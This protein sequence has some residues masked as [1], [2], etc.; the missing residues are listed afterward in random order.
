MGL[1]KNIEKN[2][3]KLMVLILDRSYNFHIAQI[4]LD[5]KIKER[6]FN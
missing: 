2:D 1:I 6:N 3:L 4:M 5:E